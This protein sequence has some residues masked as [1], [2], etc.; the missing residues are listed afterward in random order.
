MLEVPRTKLANRGWLGQSRP[1]DL[2]FNF[3]RNFV[4]DQIANREWNR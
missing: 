3:E 4:I 2:H 1:K